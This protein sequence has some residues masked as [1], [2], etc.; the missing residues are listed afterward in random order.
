M[1]AISIKKNTYILLFASKKV[2]LE[3]SAFTLKY[4]FV[5]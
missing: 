3:V 5:R 4:M 2:G 1:E